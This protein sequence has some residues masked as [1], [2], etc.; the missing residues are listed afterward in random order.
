MA[1]LIK[2][3]ASALYVPDDELAAFTSIFNCSPEA[4]GSI[5]IT[6]SDEAYSTAQT[7]LT[8]DRELEYRLEYEDFPWREDNRILIKRGLI[9]AQHRMSGRFD[10]RMAMLSRVHG[11][12]C[13]N[14]LIDTEYTHWWL[15]YHLER[16]LST[17]VHKVDAS[18]IRFRIMQ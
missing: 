5:D 9:S 15:Y 6:V 10:I 3:T 18:S 17:S 13:I 2:L 1:R 8:T 12:P 4:L 11:E 14:L 16:A 7:V